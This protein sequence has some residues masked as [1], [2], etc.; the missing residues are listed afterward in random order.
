MPLTIMK[1]AFKR[2]QPVVV[3]YI[4]SY[5]SFSNETLRKDLLNRLFNEVFVNNENGLQ[6]FCELSSNI[7]NKQAPHKKKYARGN[8][9]SFHTKK[10]SKEIMT[11]LR[12]C[13]N[14]LK[15]GMKKL[16]FST[17]KVQKK[18]TKT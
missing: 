3:N 1:K 10:L 16:C 4:R 18:I 2:F 6:R 15:T 8:Q 14:Y 17:L 12:L 7:L 11:R 13:N 9:M 5:K